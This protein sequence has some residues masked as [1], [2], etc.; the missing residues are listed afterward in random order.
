MSGIRGQMGA[1]SILAKSMLAMLLA[2]PVAAA[3]LTVEPRLAAGA[4]Y[5]DLDLDGE[6]VVDNNT[7]DNVD[8]SDWMYLVGGGLTF[9]YDRVFVDLYGQYSF[10]G[11]TDV[12]LD[13][14]AG[15]VA[16]DNLAQDVEFDR[17]ET[18]LTAGYRITDQFAAFVGFRYAD[19]TFDGTGSLGAVDADFSTD[20]NQQGPFIG[21]GYVVPKTFFNGAF[22]ANA[23]VAYLDGDLKN[24]LA[25]DGLQD[26]EFDV[27]GDAIGINAG[28]SWVTPLTS[29]LKL[30]V[31]ADIS[32]YSFQDNSDETDFDETITRLRTELRYS[33]DTGPGGS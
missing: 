24:Q 3:E 13:I 16:V 9:S 30:V 19:V 23:A 1:M 12:N 18:T 6:V 4:S 7:V 2:T 11:D 14:V 33:F 15:G 27:D 29:Q 31:G 26:V 22:V 10:D 32:R 17:V 28:A 8:F 21:A 25:A 20:F 5:Y